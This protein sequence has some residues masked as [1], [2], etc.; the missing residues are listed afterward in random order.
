MGDSRF[1]HIFS[2]LNESD[3]MKATKASDATIGDQVRV[4]GCG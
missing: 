1:T 2:A 3:Q 4:T